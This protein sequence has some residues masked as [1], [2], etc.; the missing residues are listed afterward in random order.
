ML[1][2]CWPSVADGGPTLSQHWLND[3]CLLW[4]CRWYYYWDVGPLSYQRHRHAGGIATTGMGDPCRTRGSSTI[5]ASIIFIL[6]FKIIWVFIFIFLNLK[7]VFNNRDK[8][9]I[10][11]HFGKSLGKNLLQHS[12]A[13][14]LFCMPYTAIQT[15]C[16]VA[17]VPNCVE[18]RYI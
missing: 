16:C 11:I 10:G 8:K 14:L 17:F 15:W 2:Q 7:F 3:S 12:T 4:T 5:W 6:V 18:I 1:T 13:E 9:T